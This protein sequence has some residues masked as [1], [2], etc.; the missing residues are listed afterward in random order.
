MLT[1]AICYDA[2]SLSSL[3]YSCNDPVCNKER[4]FHDDYH[5]NYYDDDDDDESKC[6]CPAD[7]SSAELYEGQLYVK[8]A[9][10]APT[11]YTLGTADLNWANISWVPLSDIQLHFAGPL[12]FN[13]DVSNLEFPSGVKGKV[14]V[15]DPNGKRGSVYGTLAYR[16]QE[17]GAVALLI[18][19]AAFNRSLPVG[20]IPNSKRWN[21]RGFERPVNS[22]DAK[23][24]TIPVYIMEA[25]AGMDLVN[26]SQEDS[27]LKI[28]L[29]RRQI[30]GNGGGGGVLRNAPLSLAI[31]C[32][33][34]LLFI[35]AANYLCLCVQSAFFH[36]GQSI[37]KLASDILLRHHTC[38]LWVYSPRNCVLP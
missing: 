1:F 27:N 23:M 31:V 11:I 33:T 34:P 22:T 37:C 36:R 6:A 4:F 32:H 24:V 28:G 38:D 10:H 15:V 21:H 18:I 12:L 3:R 17:K 2:I 26:A 5:D 16:A 8:Y 7:A 14:A 19:S 20:D 29:E 35:P 25:T 9:G 13:D 30:Q